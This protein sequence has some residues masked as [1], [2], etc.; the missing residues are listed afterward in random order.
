MSIQC[1][2][3][4]GSVLGPLLF[5]LYT[6]PLVK[7]I[8][9]HSAS[10]HLYD[11]NT[12]MR[13]ACKIE[14]LPSLVSSTSDCMID[15]WMNS[16]RPK[17]NDDKTAFIIIGSNIKKSPQTSIV[18]LVVVVVVVVVVVYR[19]WAIVLHQYQPIPCGKIP[20]YCSSQNPCCLMLEVG[21]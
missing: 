14:D 1:C 9:R 2:V 3:P 19:R 5:T 7:F 12:Q 16:N 4:Q 18:V 20:N 11:D 15:V 8:E 6:Q 17:L 21:R 13:K 10:Y